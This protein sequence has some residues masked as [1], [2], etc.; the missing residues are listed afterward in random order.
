MSSLIS[1]A[2]MALNYSVSLRGRAGKSKGVIELLEIE[3]FGA[4]ARL[5]GTVIDVFRSLSSNFILEAHLVSVIEKDITT[6]KETNYKTLLTGGK[7]IAAEIPSYF[8]EVYYFFT[9]NRVG[10]TGG[11]SDYYISTAP[12]EDILCKTALPLP[13]EMK[14]TMEPDGDGLFQMIQ[15][16]CKEKGVE[17]G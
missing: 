12:K 15:K 2:R 3:D 7:K 10:E 14:V 1:L 8:D 13:G 11:Y 6:K 4:E 5:L 16:A 17:I 9:R